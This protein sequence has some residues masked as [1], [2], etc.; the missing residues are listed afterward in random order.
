VNFA[1]L[2]LVCKTVKQQPGFKRI[3]AAAAVGTVFAVCLPLFSFTGAV[4]FLIKFSVGAVMVF[5]CRTRNFTRYCLFY[6]LFVT[7]TFTFGGAVSA[8]GNGANKLLVT[9]VLLAMIAVFGCLI[10]FLNVRACIGG[11]LR[12]T[13]IYYGDNKFR[14]NSLADTG[15]RLVDPKSAAPVCIISLSLFIKMFP[16]IEVDKLIMNRL[17]DEIN[18]GHYINYSTVSGAGKMFVFAPK[19]IE[20]AGGKTTDN[21]RLGVNFRGFGGAVKYDALLNVNML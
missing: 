19:K 2:F 3:T 21:V 20:I 5:I 17:G 16:D 11:H 4:L 14:I 13:V 18:D 7:Y 15:N 1:L 8:F 10:K 12:D 6:L 9:G